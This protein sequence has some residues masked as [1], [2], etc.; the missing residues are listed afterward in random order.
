MIMQYLETYFTQ[1]MS[2]H[3]PGTPMAVAC[4]GGSDSMALA[5]LARHHC[6]HITALTVDHGLRSES[7]E[8]AITVG[9]W[10]AAHDI[11]HAILP[12]EGSKPSVNLQEA[13]RN[14]RYRLM[15]QHCQ[16]HAIP[17]LLV[18]HTLEDQAETFLLRL[19]RGSGVDGLSAMA[20]VTMR[21]G[22]TIIR[23]LLDIRK[24][25]LTGY[26]ERCNQDYIRDP[27]NDNLKYDRVRIRQMLP[28]LAHIG[29]SVERLAKT[30]AV[31]QR[32]STHLKTE[33]ES[34][35]QH[36]CQLFA[37]GYAIL[38]ALPQSPEIALRLLGRI[39]RIIGGHPIPLRLGKLERLYAVLQGN[40]TVVT[41]GGCVFK[42]IAK[43]ILVMREL[44]AIEGVAGCRLQVAEGNNQETAIQWDRFH[45]QPATCNLHPPF[46]ISALT[47]SGWLTV[48]RQHQLENPYPDKHILYT[49]PCVRDEKG[50]IIAVPHLGIGEK[51]DVTFMVES[52][53]GINSPLPSFP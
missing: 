50:V 32:A 2:I 38:Q 42:N 29:L 25:S 23:P 30:A 20:E 51:I 19:A 52:R 26:L 16:Y 11:P 45:L 39:I 27:S 15:I 34:F 9:K 46:M 8:E 22:I 28:E 24:A 5:L 17:C 53:Q 33:T 3:A 12:W 35:M 36:H 13:A 6:R 48:A 31:M 1:K 40:F 41:L 43:G 7:A 47:Q 21:Q 44:K 14:A 4:S 37:E 49:L 18:A 10:L